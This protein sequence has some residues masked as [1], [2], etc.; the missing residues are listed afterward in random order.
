MKPVFTKI[1]ATLGPSSSSSDQIGALMWAGANAFRLNFSHGTRAEQQQ[2]IETIRRL[3]QKAKRHFSILADMQGPKLRVGEFSNGA[4]VLKNNQEFRL[5]MK[6]E[7]GNIHRVNLP[8]PEIYQVVKKGMMLLLNDGQIKLQV[9]DFGKDY[10]QTKVLIG[11][12]LSDHKGVNIPNVILPISS[13]TEKD[14]QDLK[15]ALKNNVD[16][17]CLSFVQKPEDVIYARKLI[18]D[19]AGIIVKIEKPSAIDNLEK[20]VALTDAVMVA[21]GDLGVECPIEKVPTMQ[22]QI[23]DVCRKAGKPVIV[24]TQMLESMI[25]APVPTRAEVSDIATAVYEGADCVML[26]AETASGQYP[27][28]S[29]TMMRRVIDEIQNDPYYIKSMGKTSL[30]ED[31]TIASAITS[32]MKNMI[33]VLDHPACIATYSITGKTALRASRERTSAPILSL[34]PEER[35][36]EIA[37]MLSGSCITNAAI[38]NAK[39]LLEA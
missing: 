21:R 19:K 16:W 17:I 22:R 38:Q 25:N 12:V 36:T 28:Q 9:K 26:S 29:V 18:K 15:F 33:N 35:I 31:K 14:K 8:H 23:V 2:R 39:K 4:V 11:G 30:P 3:A 7:K 32:G 24:A 10:I 5:D 27:V 1:V 34:T 6:L 13:L 20:I 37:Q